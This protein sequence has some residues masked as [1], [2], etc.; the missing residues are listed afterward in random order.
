MA[1]TKYPYRNSPYQKCSMTNILVILNIDRA[2]ADLTG[3]RKKVKQLLKKNKLTCC[4]TLKNSLKKLLT[5][6]YRNDHALPSW[7]DL[8]FEEENVIDLTMDD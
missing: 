1:R 6:Y 8:S 3:I 4:K 7:K 5:H 2:D